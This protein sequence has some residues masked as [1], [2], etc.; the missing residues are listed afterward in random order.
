[1]WVDRGGYLNPFPLPSL[2]MQSGPIGL[3][4]WGGGL[5]VP[6]CLASGVGTI[7]PLGTEYSIWPLWQARPGGN[8][9]P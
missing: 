2:A 7:P 5:W 9:G 4:G 6:S 8:H 1:M 3:F